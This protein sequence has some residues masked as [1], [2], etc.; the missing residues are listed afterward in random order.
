MSADQVQSSDD[1][2][3]L[4]RCQCPKKKVHHKLNYWIVRF[5][6]FHCD[7][8]RSIFPSFSLFN[9]LASSCLP[10]LPLLRKATLLSV[11]RSV[12]LSVVNKKWN[13]FDDDDND[14]GAGEGKIDQRQLLLCHSSV[15]SF[16]TPCMSPS[17]NCPRTFSIK[18]GPLIKGLVH[19]K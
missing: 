15:F 19:L 10:F 3:L 7:H 11:G 18:I 16:L 6:P 17:R 13:V 8:V 12:G 1:G 14:D 2:L 9:F 5:S 4:I